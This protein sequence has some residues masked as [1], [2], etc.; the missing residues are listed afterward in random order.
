MV[1]ESRTYDAVIVGAGQSG[2]P[3]ATALARAGWKVSLVERYL[4]GGSCINW[5]CTPTKTMVASARVADLARRA[6]N[7]GVQTGPVK[8]DMAAVRRRKEEIVQGFRQNL[9]RRIQGTEGVDLL[10]GEAR[11]T[12]HK[13]LAVRLNGDGGTLHLS[14]DKIFINTGGRPHVP[15]LPGLEE[16]PFLDSTSIMELDELPEHLIV[17]G[18]GY[19]GLEFAQMFR[20]FGSQVTIVQRGGQLLSE[21]DRDV[22]EAVAEI[23]RQD[24][25]EVL[26]HT[27]AQDVRVENGT[28]NLHVQDPEG[29]Q[30]IGGSHL[31]VATGRDPNT[32]ALNLAAG[33]VAVDRLGYIMADERLETNVPGIYAIGDVKGGPAFTHVS[34]DDYRILCA[35]L[36]NGGDRTVHDRPVPYVVFID[37]QLGR[38]GLTENQAREAGRR[39]RVARIPMAWAARAVEVDETRGFIKALVDAESD[40][41]LGV[42]VLGYQGGEIMAMLQVAMMGGLSYTALRDAVFTH[43]TLA[44]SLNT[45]FSSFE[46]ESSSEDT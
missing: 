38:I 18:G 39:F 29:Q 2:V 30:T 44:E 7:Y 20:R 28:I 19:V 10:M 21:E 6:G 42:A 13:A 14:A 41:I 45:L 22:A 32:D 46:E 23:L 15:Y 3:L 5:G 40:Q 26:L 11:F 4:V 16:V 37:P 17:L 1:T 27:E 34:Y 43:P 25:I 8:V 24:G 33:A 31:L 9:V 12:G 35:N 36:L